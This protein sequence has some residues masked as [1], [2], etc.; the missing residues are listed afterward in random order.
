MSLFKKKE[1]PVHNA[2]D[3]A[4]EDFSDRL[5]DVRDSM[6]KNIKEAI[7]SEYLIKLLPDGADKEAE[8]KYLEGKKYSLLC[9]IGAYD[10]IVADW[11][12]MLANASQ[13]LKDTRITEINPPKITSHEYL[14]RT[15]K[16]ALESLNY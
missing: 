16:R 1:I 7:L 15:I 5:W 11:K 13:E 6:D 4:C 9:N 2:L 8:Q 3:R 14:R 12:N 10:G